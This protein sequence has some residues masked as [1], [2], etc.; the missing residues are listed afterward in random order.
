MQIRIH[1]YS[2]C[3]ELAGAETVAETV[4]PGSRIRDLWPVVFARFP[5]LGPMQK[6]LLVAVGVDYQGADYELR[7]GDEVSIFPPVQGG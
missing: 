7:E 5:K 1:F 6:S 3:K 4:P 2:Y